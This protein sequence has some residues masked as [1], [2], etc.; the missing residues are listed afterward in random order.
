MFVSTIM[1]KFVIVRQPLKTKNASHLS[2]L[3]KA[4]EVTGVPRSYMGACGTTAVAY[5][6]VPTDLVRLVFQQCLVDQGVG[7]AHVPTVEFGRIKF[8]LRTNETMRKFN[9]KCVSFILR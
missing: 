2:P 9:C 8:T 3:H 5:V 7:P 4:S 1:D 6:G